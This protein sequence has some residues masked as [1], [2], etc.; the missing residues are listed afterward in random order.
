MPK[1]VLTMFFTCH[2][3][4][5][6]PLRWFCEIYDCTCHLYII[7]ACSWNRHSYNPKEVPIWMEDFCSGQTCKER[8]KSSIKE[9]ILP[10]LP[11]CSVSIS[12]DSIMQKSLQS[13]SFPPRLRPELW[14]PLAL[15]AR[16]IRNT[17]KT[18][19]WKAG[20]EP[21]LGPDP[22]RG[23]QM[24][25]LDPSSLST[26]VGKSTGNKDPIASHWVS[27]GVSK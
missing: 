2:N 9:A 27:P 13:P 11:L 24:P 25:C 3:E 15:R 12:C 8:C 10:L 7:T 17:S 21:P 1:N 22:R 5:Q 19:H 18:E 6:G 4:F 26:D 16:N 14:Q 23:L 20:Q